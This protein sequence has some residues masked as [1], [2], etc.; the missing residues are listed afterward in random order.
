MPRRSAVLRLAKVHAGGHGYYLEAAG[1]GAGVGM[2]APGQWL[3]AG[4]AALGLHGVVDASALGAVLRGDD[5]ATGQ[6]LGPWHDRVTVAAFDLS[7][8]APKSVSLL[9]ALAPPDVA[10]EVHEAHGR[11]VAAALDYVERRAVAVRRP[12]DGTPV[13]VAADA[14]PAAGFVHRVSRALDPHLHTHVVLAN[15][16][17]DGT[18]RFSA[19]DGRGLY[20]HAAAADALYHAHLRHELTSR[21][22][23]AWEPLRSGRADVAGIGHEARLAFSQ[24][25]VAIAEH[26]ASRRLGGPRA[27][28]IAGHATRPGR[29][30]TVSVEGLRP[31]WE[32]RARE[33]GLGPG[34][35]EA[36]LDRVSRRAGPGPDEAR[37]GAVVDALGRRAP[38][39][40]RRDVVRAWC[41]TLPAGAPAPAVEAAAERTVGSLA[42]T[43]SHAARAE[44][45]G[46]GERRY[47]L[48]GR[49]HD[50]P[51]LDPASAGR[52][53][54]RVAGRDGDQLAAL[55]ARRDMRVARDPGRG[56]GRTVDVDGGMGLG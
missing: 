22:G 48:D 28:D 34:R 35:L 42:T 5:P 29:D 54:S 50:G 2:E 18:G 31:G 20:A 21:L 53:A 24:R 36:T 51:G 12:V 44:R 45:P 1:A 49:R 47:A 55:L 19:V 26:L 27:K 30:L 33:V 6:R 16:G 23:V 17:R 56:L 41:T 46:V 25:A 52:H 40:F 8:C 11:A 4:S 9:H 39:A 13:P 15:L 10:G 37:R 38:T 3:G 7:F 43:P 14:V 32:R